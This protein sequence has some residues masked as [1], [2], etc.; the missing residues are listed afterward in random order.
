MKLSGQTE[1]R[2]TSPC[3][4]AVVSMG[5]VAQQHSENIVCNLDSLLNCRLCQNKLT[6]EVN[7]RKD[8]T[9]VI[10]QKYTLEILND[11]SKCRA[12]VEKY[13][14][15]YINTD[16]V[17]IASPLICTLISTKKDFISDIV[18]LNP[19]GTEKITKFGTLKNI[20]IYRDYFARKD[21][22]EIKKSFENNLAQL[23]DI[24]ENQDSTQQTNGDADAK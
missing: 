18:P 15:P 20:T 2:T 23:N 1:L 9:C 22:I 13:F 6:L 8:E 3:C 12:L 19:E 24:E 7:M 21:Y 17:V 5:S 4:H 10:W 16:C 14:D 11:F